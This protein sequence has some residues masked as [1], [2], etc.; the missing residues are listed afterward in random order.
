MKLY[1]GLSEMYILG[2]KIQESCTKKIRE[3]KKNLRNIDI[4]LSETGRRTHTL[5]L[6]CG[7]SNTGAS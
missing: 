6:Y 1:K 7:M 2:K 5:P 4:I 3:N